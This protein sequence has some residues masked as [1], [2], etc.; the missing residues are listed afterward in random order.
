MIRHGLMIIMT[1]TGALTMSCTSP[2]PLREDFGRSVAAI[3]Q[4]Q[5]L[6]HAIARGA[7]HLDG[8]NGQAAQAVIRRYLGSFEKTDASAASMTPTQPPPGFTGA[9]GAPGMPSGGTATSP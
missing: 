2:T 6:D 3:R 8:L 9:L 1:I 5:R 4:A 7:T